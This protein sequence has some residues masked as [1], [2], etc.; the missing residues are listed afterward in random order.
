MPTLELLEEHLDRLDELSADDATQS[1]PRWCMELGKILTALQHGLLVHGEQTQDEDSLFA[2]PEL[3]R[4]SRQFDRLLRKDG[5]FLHQLAHLNEEVWYLRRAIIRAR[6]MEREHFS[7]RICGVPDLAGI[8]CK[9]NE[10][11]TA[12]RQHMHDESNLV[13][14]G[15]TTD[16]GAGD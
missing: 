3:V 5:E 10:L 12:I 1:G 16:I 11:S 4:L 9:A 13:L 8:R 2:E 7:E 6:A 15:I 14:E